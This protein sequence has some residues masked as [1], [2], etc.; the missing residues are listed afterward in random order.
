MF[1]FTGIHILIGDKVLGMFAFLG[2]KP[3]RQYPALH[4]LESS[5]NS[6]GPVA[7]NV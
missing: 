4:D 6:F 5:G 7:G 3:G 1:S 2:R